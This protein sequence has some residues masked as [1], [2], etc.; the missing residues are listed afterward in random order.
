[1]KQIIIGYTYL[2]LFKLNLINDNEILKQV[3]HRK[4]KCKHCSININNWCNKKKGGCGCFLP[5][6]WFVKN[7]K[8]PINKWKI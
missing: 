6:S 7:K 5:A 3:K 8:C 2:I 4:E 1:M